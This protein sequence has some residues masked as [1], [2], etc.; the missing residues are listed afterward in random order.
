MIY[1]IEFVR[2]VDGKAEAMA[3][4][5]IKLVGDGVDAVIIQADEL[6]KTLATVPRPNGYRIRESDGSLVHEFVEPA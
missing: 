4:H 3:L 2:R 5:A 1:D 6:L